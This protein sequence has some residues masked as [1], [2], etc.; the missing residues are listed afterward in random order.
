MGESRWIPSLVTNVKQSQ[1]GLSVLR[2]IVSDLQAATALTS[3][4]LRCYNT[5]L[6]RRCSS[7]GSSDLHEQLNVGDIVQFLHNPRAN[8][9]KF[10][11]ACDDY[12]VDLAFYVIGALSVSLS[13]SVWAAVRKCDI[14]SHN[15]VQIPDFMKP[16][17]ITATV[18]HHFKFESTEPF[19]VLRVDHRV[20][21]VGFLHS[22]SSTMSCTDRCS[23]SLGGSPFFLFARN[24]GY[25]TRRS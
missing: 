17:L 6:F 22:C 15:S 2:R 10:I 23:T 1:T 21:K 5:I 3:N 4:E 13:G 11:F 9:D 8:T 24:I 7:L 16:C 18:G 19:Q 14:H 25:P 20:Q 12:N